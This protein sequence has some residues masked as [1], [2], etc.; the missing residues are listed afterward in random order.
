MAV[1]YESTT[2]LAEVADPGAGEKTSLGEAAR[3]L[4]GKVISARHKEKV[5]V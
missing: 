5:A 2:R 1:K 3:P 4:V